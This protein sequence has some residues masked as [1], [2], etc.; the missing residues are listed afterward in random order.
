MPKIMGYQLMVG[1]ATISLY[2]GNAS[3]IPVG[4]GLTSCESVRTPAKLLME[5]SHKLSE[6]EQDIIVDARQIGHSIFEIVG[7][8]DI[9]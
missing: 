7:S 5:R 6:L 3:T 8:L 1:D 2:P 4:C 9:T